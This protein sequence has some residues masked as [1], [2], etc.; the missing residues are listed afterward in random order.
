[1]RVC[2]LN[3]YGSEKADDLVIAALSALANIEY[4]SEYKEAHLLIFSCHTPGKQIAK[5]GPHR[6]PFLRRYVKTPICEV[7]ALP[8]QTTLFVSVESP[9][10]PRFLQSGCDFGISHEFLP[11]CVN[12][13]RLPYWNYS[14]DWSAQGIYSNSAFRCGKKIQPEELVVPRKV[15]ANG[16]QN[17]PLL[18][19]S[20][21]LNGFKAFFYDEFRRHN[22]IDLMGGQHGRFMSKVDIAHSG[23]YLFSLCPEN[24]IYPG[25]Y[26][27]K[28]LESWA[29]GF[30]PVTCHDKLAWLEFNEYSYINLYD[31]IPSGIAKAFRDISEDSSILKRAIDTPLMSEI[32]SIVPLV[33]FL[34]NLLDVVRSRS[35]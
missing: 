23:K 21:H 22:R 12:H 10:H 33:N 14:I 30:I 15:W 26:T 19:M 31:Q 34:E 32:P 18:M 20:S 1:M 16:H 5:Y 24:S 7:M 9:H 11:S 27:E 35:K 6:I 29:C 4:V 2:L 3:W 8:H 25:Y 17:T 13:F 28:V